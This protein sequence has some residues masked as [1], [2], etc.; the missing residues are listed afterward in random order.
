MYK[1]L[2]IFIII[3]IIIIIIMSSA[4]NS[5]FSNLKPSRDGRKA[6]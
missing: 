3:I 4:R 1:L 5:Y 6:A 2:F